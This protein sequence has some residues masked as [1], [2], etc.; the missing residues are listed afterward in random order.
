MEV[1]LL[2]KDEKFIFCTVCGNKIG[3]FRKWRTKRL[4]KDP[5]HLIPLSQFCCD[6]CASEG[7]RFLME[8]IEKK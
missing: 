3:W 7:L 5:M 4:D 6:L 8:E 1:E 2:K